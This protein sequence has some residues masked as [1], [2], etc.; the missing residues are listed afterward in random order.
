M[1]YYT[2][3]VYTQVV[4]WLKVLVWFTCLVVLTQVVVWF[5]CGGLRNKVPKLVLRLKLLHSTNSHFYFC[6]NRIAYQKTL[7]VAWPKSVL[8]T[9]IIDSLIVQTIVI[10]SHLQHGKASLQLT[11]AFVCIEIRNS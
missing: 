5:T 8:K 4:V 9:R 3:R 7:V 2:D 11:C 10:M 6:M 1:C